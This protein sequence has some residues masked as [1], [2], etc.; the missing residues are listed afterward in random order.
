VL[1]WNELEWGGAGER[2]AEGRA[3][4]SH[5]MF[6]NSCAKRDNNITHKEEKKRV[7]ER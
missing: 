7:E 1:R 4:N 6:I 5:K 3:H 2:E